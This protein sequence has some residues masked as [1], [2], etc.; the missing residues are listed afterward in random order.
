M[1]SA[2]LQY[3]VKFTFVN[4]HKQQHFAVFI[5]CE[6]WANSQKKS[7]KSNTAKLA[8]VKINFLEVVA[9]VSFSLPYF[10]TLKLSKLWIPK[11]SSYWWHDVSFFLTWPKFFSSPKIKKQ[12]H[13]L[14][15]DLTTISQVLETPGRVYHQHH[16]TPPLFTDTILEKSCMLNRSILFLLRVLVVRLT[17]QQGSTY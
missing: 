5:F 9:Q 15:N 12:S 11:S 3:F 7:A 6:V 10:L 8:F 16:P 13:D 14:V 2:I 4:C 1:C 17:D